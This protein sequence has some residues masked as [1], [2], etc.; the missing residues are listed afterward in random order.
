VGSTEYA[1]VRTRSRQN[2]R[3]VVPRTLCL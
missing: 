3:Q 1:G 2:C